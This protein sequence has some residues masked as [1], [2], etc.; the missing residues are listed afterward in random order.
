M[1]EQQIYNI[2]STIIFFALTS[3]W[4]SDN[5]PNFI[6]KIILAIVTFIGVI[7]NIQYFIK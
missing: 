3:V 2:I 5:W 1:S 6:I 7:L 4:K